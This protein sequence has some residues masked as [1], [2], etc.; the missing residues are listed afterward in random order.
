MTDI[1]ILWNQEKQICDWPIVNNDFETD[2]DIESSILVSLFTWRVAESSWVG[3]NGDNNRYGWWGDAF[4]TWPIGSRLWQLQRL[5][6]ADIDLKRATD[7]CYEA[8]KWM[9]DNNIVTNLVVNCT[10][11]KINTSRMNIVITCNKPNI[12]ALKAYNFSWAWNQISSGF[13]ST[14]TSIPGTILPSQVIAPITPPAPIP[15]SSIIDE[16]FDLNQSLIK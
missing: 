14:N 15:P 7:L 9:T 13:P 12:S 6:K 3:F 2:S 1:R 8:L 16:G 4:R 11:D 5:K 10:W